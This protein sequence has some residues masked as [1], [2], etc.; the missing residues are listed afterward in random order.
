M[1]SITFHSKTIDLN[2]IN[3][4]YFPIKVEHN[5]SIESTKYVGFY[6]GDTDL[7]E[8]SVDRET[9]SIRKFILVL[10]NHYEVLDMEFQ[11]ATVYK[12]GS[13]SLNLPQHN[14][15]NFFRTL[16]YRNAVDI[17]LSN[18]T[19]HSAIK[20]GQVLFGLS[21]DNELVSVTVVEMSENDID[22]TIEEL[23]QG[24]GGMTNN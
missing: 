1:S 2:I 21:E 9:N 15:C 5:P 7:L 22:H 8:F 19:V 16:V 23:S 11:S 10:C 3:E 17:L 13:I 14:E 4:D 18:K 12:R 6:F 24:G 20:C